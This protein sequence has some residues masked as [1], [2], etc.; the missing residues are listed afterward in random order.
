MSDQ[1]Q[2]AVSS[3]KAFQSEAKRSE[4]HNNN[5]S[6]S[7]SNDTDRTRQASQV[8]IARQVDML[9]HNPKAGASQNLAAHL[10]YMRTLSTWY[11]TM[12]RIA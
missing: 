11:T 3:E 1:S 2:Q 7:S 8:D 9:Y 5:Y 6:D 12:L 4:Q 10:S